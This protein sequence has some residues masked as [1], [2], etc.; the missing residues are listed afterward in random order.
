[1]RELRKRLGFVGPVGDE[2]RERSRP[3]PTNASNDGPWG[4]NRKCKNR[5]SV[6]GLWPAAAL[7]FIR[8][9]LE[10]FE[11]LERWNFRLFRPSG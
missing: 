7:G 5:C 8:A 4:L 1:V 11:R 6:P 3:F 9:R 10:P 2:S